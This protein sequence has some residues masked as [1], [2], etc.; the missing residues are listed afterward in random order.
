MQRE[1]LV[2]IVHNCTEFQRNRTKN[3]IFPNRSVSGLLPEKLKKNFS[4]EPGNIVMKFWANGSMTC[5]IFAI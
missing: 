4:K 1:P 3:T 5:Q 2:K